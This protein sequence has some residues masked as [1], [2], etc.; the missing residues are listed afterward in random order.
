MSIF[1][2]YS[3]RFLC[4]GNRTA[5]RKRRERAFFSHYL[6]QF[7]FKMNSFQHLYFKFF[8]NFRKNQKI[9]GITFLKRFWKKQKRTINISINLHDV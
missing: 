4:I 9:E 3:F 5:P 8:T 6:Q 2:F 7:D 1:V